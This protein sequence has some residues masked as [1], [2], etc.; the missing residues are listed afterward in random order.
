MQSRAIIITSIFL[1]S[2][3]IIFSLTTLFHTNALTLRQPPAPSLTSN[4]EDL[5]LS[6]KDTLK[7]PGREDEPP[8]NSTENLNDTQ[9]QSQGY[10]VP[11]ATSSIDAGLIGATPTGSQVDEGYIGPI[12]T[13]ASIV[14]RPTPQPPPLPPPQAPTL[15][16]M[17]ASYTGS[18]GPKHCRGTVISTI[19]LPPPA[20]SHREGACF[21]LPVMARCGIF[22]ANK[23]DNCEAQLFN[24]EGCLNTSTTFL[25]TVVFMPE[26]R[27]VGAYWKSMWLRCGVEAP[28][29]SLLDPGILKGLLGGG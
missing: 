2:A 25:N 6:Q 1:I 16:I 9:L 15:P 7:V 19:E 26:E 27:V 14:L 22:I 29:A 28:D 18:G 24:A 12:E 21:D 20:S 5:D 4:L 23:D 13:S 11:D 8:Y 10:T 17:A 3:I